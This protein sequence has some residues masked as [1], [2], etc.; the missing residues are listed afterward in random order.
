MKREKQ[1]GIKKKKNHDKTSSITL[2][3]VKKKSRKTRAQFAQTQ[4]QV[5]NRDWCSERRKREREKLNNYFLN[6]VVKNVRP[7]SKGAV[8]LVLHTRRRQLSCNHLLMFYHQTSDKDMTYSRLLY[9]SVCLDPEPSD[10]VYC[11]VWR[12]RGRV[13]RSL[14]QAAPMM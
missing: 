10:N 14:P 2:W 4:E 3:W 13:R 7:T 9:I 12:C 6:T 5:P 1:L 8:I 11:A